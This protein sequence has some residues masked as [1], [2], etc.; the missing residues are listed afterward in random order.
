MDSLK[1][2]RAW[3]EST[4]REL[5]SDSPLPPQA[6]V[7][8]EAVEDLDGG[9]AAHV[10]PLFFGALHEGMMHHAVRDPHACVYCGRQYQ[11]EMRSK[12]VQTFLVVPPGKKEPA[13]RPP[14]CSSGGPT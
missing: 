2:P 8:V 5:L 3:S 13:Q 12:A 10:D 1:P 6:A 11:Q 9:N 7:T 4:A 14:L